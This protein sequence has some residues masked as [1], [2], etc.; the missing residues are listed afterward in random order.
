MLWVLRPPHLRPHTHPLPS[1]PLSAPGCSRIA[2]FATQKQPHQA[3]RE[4]M[5]KYP[6]VLNL[7]W[8]KALLRDVCIAISSLVSA[9]SAP[10]DG[11]GL[12]R[13]ILGPRP[14]STEPTSLE[15]GSWNPQVTP[16][17]PKFNSSILHHHPELPGG[18]PNLTSC[19][20]NSTVFTGCLL[21]PVSFPSSPT[22]LPGF[23]SE[24]N[25]L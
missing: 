24:I 20:L 6:R 13:R 11:S 18:G 7:W 2:V 21:F 15:V 3:D 12:E 14:R 17:T 8:R 5:D 9:A 10:A 22:T 16:C 1:R 4:L 25:D 19:L 23:A